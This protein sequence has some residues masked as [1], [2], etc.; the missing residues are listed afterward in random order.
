M[1][2]TEG[3]YDAGDA[4]EYIRARDA[5]RELSRAGKDTQN[6]AERVKDADKKLKRK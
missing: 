1:S 4:A 5:H 2:N 3:N 6:D